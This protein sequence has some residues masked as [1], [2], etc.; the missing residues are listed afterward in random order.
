MSLFDGLS[1]S[2]NHC[3]ATGQFDNLKSLPQLVISTISLAIDT[4]KSVN[5]FKSSSAI[6]SALGYSDDR[7]TTHSKPARHM[8]EDTGRLECLL[9]FQL[10]YK[11]Y[12]R[13]QCS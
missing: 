10:G 8:T 7:V 2:A 13:I 1:R 6:N 11:N 4:L 9:M 12:V 3:L 5:L